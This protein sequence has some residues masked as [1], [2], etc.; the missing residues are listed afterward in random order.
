M[1]LGG[2]EG[3]VVLIRS[4]ES[5]TSPSRFTSMHIPTAIQFSLATRADS[6]KDYSVYSVHWLF[7]DFSGVLR[8]LLSERR[9]GQQLAPLTRRWL[10]RTSSKERS[11][12]QNG[13]QQSDSV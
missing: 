12:A 6:S 11:V 2:R 7:K 9:V 1:P 10:V 4:S 13:E 3:S 8:A 5:C